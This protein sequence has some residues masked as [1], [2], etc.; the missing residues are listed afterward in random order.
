MLFSFVRLAPAPGTCSQPSR[1]W[2]LQRGAHDAPPVAAM[3]GAAVATLRML[4]ALMGPVCAG[5]AP[6]VRA[7]AAFVAGLGQFPQVQDRTFFSIVLPH[8][9]RILLCQ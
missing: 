4:A 5:Y 1:D 9:T 3:A 2:L 6:A 8:L 7:A